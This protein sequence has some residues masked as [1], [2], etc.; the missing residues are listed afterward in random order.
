MSLISSSLLF[1]CANMRLLY[2]NIDCRSVGQTESIA[3]MSVERSFLVD[4]SCSE[5]SDVSYL[6][7]E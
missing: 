3:A 1:C 4:E 2:D 6:V 7:G 5:S